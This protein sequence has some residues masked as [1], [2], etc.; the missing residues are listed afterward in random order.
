MIRIQ[1]EVR[2]DRVSSLHLL[3]LA[4]RRKGS[5]VTGAVITF[6]RTDARLRSGVILKYVLPRYMLEKG[7]CWCHSCSPWSRARSPT[8]R[9]VQ[10]TPRARAPLVSPLVPLQVP[11][12]EHLPPLQGPPVPPPRHHPTQPSASPNRRPTTISINPNRTNLHP[13]NSPSHQ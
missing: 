7:T 8:R 3:L 5:R 4:R 1:V 10:P 12:P 9:Q 13:E 6:S 11:L 2:I